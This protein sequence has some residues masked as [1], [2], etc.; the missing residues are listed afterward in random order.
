MRRRPDSY[1]ARMSKP[2]Y[3]GSM[4]SRDYKCAGVQQRRTTPA[5]YSQG[6]GA[7][8]AID[9]QALTSPDRPDFGSHSVRWPLVNNEL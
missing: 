7:Q 2:R 5:S 9:G 3:Q 8:M 1:S 6:R 4:A